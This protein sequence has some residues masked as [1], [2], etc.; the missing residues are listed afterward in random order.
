MT[1]FGYHEQIKA[2]TGPLQKL[3]VLSRA[4]QTLCDNLLA[5]AAKP[6]TFAANGRDAGVALAKGVKQVLAEASQLEQSLTGCVFVRVCIGTCVS[7]M[8]F[9]AA[10]S[11]VFTCLCMPCKYARTRA[12]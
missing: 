5:S 4:A 10:H 1:D 9:H 7:V 12:C 8:G 2:L 3:E 6:D 11:S